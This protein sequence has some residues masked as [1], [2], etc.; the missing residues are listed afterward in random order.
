MLRMPNDNPRLSGDQPLGRMLAGVVI[1]LAAVR[2]F[3]L[4]E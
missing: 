4:G 2:Y 1:D 3:L